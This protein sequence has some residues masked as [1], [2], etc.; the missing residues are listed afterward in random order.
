M[1]EGTLQHFAASPQQTLAPPTFH[2]PP[3]G[4]YRRLLLRFTFPV[5][6]W[7]FGNGN[8]SP[9]AQLIHR[10]QTRSAVIALVRHHLA[11]PAFMNSVF[12]LCRRRADLFS[13]RTSGRRQG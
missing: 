5:A 1:R 6:P 12:A 11:H 13:H 9:N 8:V 2:A 7:L 4:V 10:L 3:V